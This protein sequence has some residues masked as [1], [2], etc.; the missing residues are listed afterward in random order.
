VG[1]RPARLDDTLRPVNRRRR[2]NAGSAVAALAIACALALAVG[3]KNSQRMDPGASPAQTAAARVS[4][5]VAGGRDVA[6]RV[7]LARTP[8]EREQGLMY[9]TQM[10]SDAGMLFIFERP[11]DLVFW[12]KNTLIPLDMIFIGGD[13][14]IAGIVENAQPE[15]LTGRRVDGP[16]QYVLEINGGLSSKLGIKAGAMVTFSGIPGS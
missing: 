2:F 13:R 8:A 1:R 6:F 3:C 7:E 12:M 16:A 10:A 5:A 14:R 4:V 11:S 15:T 9:R